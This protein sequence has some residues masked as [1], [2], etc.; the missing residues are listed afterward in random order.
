M[1]GAVVLGERIRSN[2]ERTIFT[3]KSAIIPVRVS[4]GFAVVII[5]TILGITVYAPACKQLG[6]AI[7]AGDASAEAA[8]SRKLLTTNAINALMLLVAVVA[9]VGAWGLRAPS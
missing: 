4:I 9:M 8:A 6:A 3:Y 1:E 5:G 2:V 7:D